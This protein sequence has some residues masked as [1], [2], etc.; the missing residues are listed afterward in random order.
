MLTQD[1]LLTISMLA[2]RHFLLLVAAMRAFSIAAMIAMLAVPAHAQMG[3]GK[4]GGKLGQKS[5]EQIAAEQQIKKNE[6]N[7]YKD[8]MKKIP[9]QPIKQTDPWANMRSK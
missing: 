3:H 5:D 1:R 9:D 8:A 7:A 4:G 2:S 6:E